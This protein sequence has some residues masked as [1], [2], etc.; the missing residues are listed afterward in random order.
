M[1]W[2]AFYDWLVASGL[3]PTTASRRMVTARAWYEGRGAGRATTANTREAYWRAS[4]DLENYQ[5]E[6][7]L[8]L[9]PTAPKPE[10]ARGRAR[11]KRAL[12]AVSIDDTGYEALAEALARDTEPASWVVRVLLYTG[13][14]VSDILRTDVHTLTAA[15]ARDDGLLLLTV[16]G[17]KTLFTSVHVCPVEWK[18]ILEHAGPAGSLPLWV[19][20]YGDGSPE[21][22]RAAYQAVARR[23]R[24]LAAK[25]GVTGR[26]H[27]HR[28]RRTFIVRS[29]AAGTPAH[30]VQQAVGHND[31]RT[32]MRYS[33]EV[34]TDWIQDAARAARGEHR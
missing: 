32:T 23:L 20:P 25:A 5:R 1:N 10:R 26:V 29:L 33:D 9:T 2:Q 18:Y 31:L 7:N 11:P 24:A 19:A 12:D 6:H 28:L 27:L 16:K 13:Q 22:G 30:K 15:F 3:R 17:G 4:R 34:R 8:P 21:A 14:R